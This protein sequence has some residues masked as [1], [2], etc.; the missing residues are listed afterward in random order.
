MLQSIEQVVAY[1][2]EF[3]T[4]V[5]IRPKD[6][7]TKRK[8]DANSNIVKINIL[9]FGKEEQ[10]LITELNKERIRKLYGQFN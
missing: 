6:P 2:D 3:K 10:E 4:I 7:E 8:V 1:H 9:A 5:E